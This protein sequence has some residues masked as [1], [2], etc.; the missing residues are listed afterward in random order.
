MEVCWVTIAQAHLSNLRGMLKYPT[1][2]FPP[3]QRSSSDSTTF[4]P[5]RAFSFS[6][7]LSSSLSLS[8]YHTL[9]A[10]TVSVDRVLRRF[11]SCS[12]LFPRFFLLPFS[13][14]FSGEKFFH[15]HCLHESCAS[16]LSVSYSFLCAV[17]LA[18]FFCYF[19]PFVLFFLMTRCLFTFI[20][21]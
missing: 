7:F 3:L 8:L 15:L 18:D 21:P 20:R 10:F 17:S 4:D 12:S 16:S 13:L 6:P 5:L 11:H 2:R 19:V 14:S 9:Y 1:S